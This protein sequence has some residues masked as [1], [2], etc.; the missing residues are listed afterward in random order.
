MTSFLAAALGTLVLLVTGFV[1]AG[2]TF[3]AD[4]EL[5][6]AFLLAGSG[7]GSMLLLSAAI[8]TGIRMSRR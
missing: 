6:L 1:G 4:P 7:L 3:G 2:T 5:T 8:A